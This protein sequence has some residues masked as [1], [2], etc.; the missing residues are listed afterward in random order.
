MITLTHVG[1]YGLSFSVK[2]LAYVRLTFSV[3]EFAT[4]S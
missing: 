3:L 4:R 2:R 1:G